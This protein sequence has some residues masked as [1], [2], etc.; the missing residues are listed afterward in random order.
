MAV[1]NVGQK[2]AKGGRHGAEVR[3]AH[4]AGG[5]ILRRTTGEEVIPEKRGQIGGREG[6]DCGKQG[7]EDRKTY[8]YNRAE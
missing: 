7:G 1:G 3:A 5:G 8:C 4:G 2:K 6:N